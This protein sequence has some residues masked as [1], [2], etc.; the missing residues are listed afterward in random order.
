MIP[1]LFDENSTEFKTNG[2]GRLSDAI[3]CICTEERNGIYEVEMEYPVTGIHFSEIVMDSILVVVPCDG[4]EKQPFRVYL[5]SKPISGRVRINARHISYQLSNIT[6]MPFSVTMAASACRETLKGLKENAVDACPFT[7]ETDVTTGAAYNQTVPRSIRASLGGIEGSV[8]DQFGGEY[9][10]DNYRVILHNRRGRINT[11]ITL[12]YGKNIT[13]I[14]QEENI[15]NTVTGVVPF[16]VD[17]NGEN[18]VILP[19]K[20]I[21]SRYADNYPYKLTIPLDLSSNW[22][23]KPS[24]ESLRLAAQAYVHHAELGTPKVSIEVSFI[25]LWQ[26]EEYKDI[27][28]LQR[29]QLCDEVSVDFE[30]LGIKNVL[31]KVVKTEYNVLKDRY[32]SITI[33]NLRTSLISAIYEK[34]SET[35]QAIADSS[36]RALRAA[37]VAAFDAI[38]NATAWLTNA[39]GYVV[40]VKDEDGNWKEILFMDSN[41]PNV[42]VNVLRIN[43]NGLGFSTTGIAGP[44]TNAWTIDGNLVADFITAGILKDKRNTFVLD[45]DKG[46]LTLSDG[47]KVG[48]TTLKEMYTQITANKNGIA[49]EIVNRGKAISDEA[50]AREK[51]DGTLQANITA[52]AEELKQEI[53]AIST[54]NYVWR[55]AYEPTAYNSPASDWN[56]TKL[57]EKHENDVFFNVATGNTYLWKYAIPATAITFKA[58]SAISDAGDYVRIYYNNGAGNYRYTQYNDLS[59]KRIVIPRY[60]NNIYIF[61][62]SDSDSNTDYGFA[63]EEIEA[64]AIV[65]EDIERLFPYTATAL[66]AHNESQSCYNKTSALANCQT[67]HPYEPSKDKLWTIN[68]SISTNGIGWQW[69]LNNDISIT[70]SSL[71]QTANGLISE[72]M[73]REAGDTALSSQISQSANEIKS[74]VARSEK[75]WDEEDYNITLYGYGTPANNGYAAASYSGK[76]YLDQENGRLYLSNGN[77]WSLVKTMTRIVVSLQ[78]QIKQNA[79]SISLKVS[80]GDISSQLSL[81]SGQIKLATGRLIIDSGNFTIDKNGNV[82]ITSTGTGLS[83]TIKNGV[84]Q[85]FDSTE[86]RL[87]ITQAFLAGY[88]KELNWAQTGILDLS[89][90]YGDKKA[91]AALKGNDI[92]HLQAGNTVSIESKSIEV[93]NGSTSHKAYTGTIGA[94]YKVNVGGGQYAWNNLSFVNGILVGSGYHGHEE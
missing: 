1:I 25:A 66:P 94:Y 88:S 91:H 14:T 67:S 71:K 29:V 64:A 32:N 56:T 63:I 80:K 3:S 81:E 20:V 50:D 51:A 15:S 90:Y 84:I 43:N 92:L 59:C 60:N 13:D 58:A 21:Y 31:A 48:D 6:C 5:I 45:L 78:S 87:D 12:K 75:V 86:E 4:G 26:T 76:Y 46:T 2:I 73:A 83:I 34:D 18:L 35:S 8:L 38:N 28:P 70:Y 89:P 72:V 54:G 10:F 41:D 37:G 23:E 33:G 44:Y 55:G 62:H 11:G 22:E 68:Y 40:A 30:K 65:E 69:V 42:A 61:F 9:E 53:A 79:D 82:G 36:I 57:K 16:W 93:G 47:T 77:S 17:L 7:F 24:V 74:T 39:N 52:T 19:E 85:C 49:A 27:A